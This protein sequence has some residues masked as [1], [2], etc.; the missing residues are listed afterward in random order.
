M[1]DTTDDNVHG[2]RNKFL[3]EYES[4][5]DLYHP[6]DAER[7]GTEDYQVRRFLLSSNNDQHKAYQ[8]LTKALKWKKSFGIHDRIDDYF[9]KEFRLIFGHEKYSRDRKGRLVVWTQE[10]RYRKIADLSP[11]VEQYHAHQMEKLDR[12]AGPNGYV[13]VCECSGSGFANVDINMSKFRGN[14][15]TY[16]PEAC[17]VSILIGLP[18]I[19]RSSFNFIKSLFDK[20][21]GNSFALITKEQIVNYVEPESI[22]KCF[23][24]QRECSLNDI[25]LVDL[26]SLREC[27][28][29]GL[30]EKQIYKF[31]DTYTE[32]IDEK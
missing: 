27:K 11:L 12:E 5:P 10:D 29:L 31:Y 16:Y 18:W 1:S 15:L 9:P 3:A 2:L 20:Q 13:S 24:G 28:H 25:I 26:K 22:P 6:I 30:N 21:I 4:M 7:V 8:Q 23:D 19:L 17:Q 14:L 32:Y